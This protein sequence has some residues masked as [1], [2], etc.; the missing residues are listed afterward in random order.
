M[1]KATILVIAAGTTLLAVSP[2]AAQRPARPEQGRTRGTEMLK[3]LD[4]RLDRMEKAIRTMGQ[5]LKQLGARARVQEKRLQG[6]EK[7]GTKGLRTRRP[8]QVRARVLRESQGQGQPAPQGMDK[9]R[10]LAMKKMAQA[11]RSQAQQR[12][13]AIRHRIEKRIEAV[14]QLRHRIEKR[15]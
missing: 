12:R 9:K 4:Q 8:E 3:R 11:R 6:L 1:K 7:G 13:T 5:S 10:L 15:V 14:P 2:L